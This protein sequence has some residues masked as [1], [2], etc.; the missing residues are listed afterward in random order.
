MKIFHTLAVVLA[1]VNPLVLC[2]TD[3]HNTDSVNQ[4]DLGVRIKD[5]FNSIS[6]LHGN[7]LTFFR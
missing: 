1:A 6:L 4:D 2:E 3:T 7:L 5:S